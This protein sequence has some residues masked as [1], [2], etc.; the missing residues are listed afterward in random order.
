M[1]NSDKLKVDLQSLADL[2]SFL[3]NEDFDK[4]FEALST[5]M[6]ELT[7]SWMDLEGEHFK[8]VFQS[9]MNDAKK[10]NGC[11][12]TLGAFATTMSSKYQETLN[13]HL[14]QLKSVV[15]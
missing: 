12:E 2:G 4:D 5:A 10:I 9:F 13:T 14:E 1:E 15:N 3:S 11:V 8:T 6:S 7:S